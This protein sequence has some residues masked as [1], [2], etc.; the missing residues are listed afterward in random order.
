MLK[1]PSYQ[2]KLALKQWTIGFVL[3]I[4]ELSLF[5]LEEIKTLRSVWNLETETSDNIIFFCLLG[6]EYNE[7]FMSVTIL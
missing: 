1:T 6:Q 5:L 2:S 4:E 3:S 7:G